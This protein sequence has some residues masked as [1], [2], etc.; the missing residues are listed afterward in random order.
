MMYLIALMRTLKSMIL[1]CLSP[2]LE[3][4]CRSTVSEPYNFVHRLHVEEDLTWKDLS[5]NEALSNLQLVEK[6]G[7]GYVWPPLYS[8]ASKIALSHPL[9]PLDDDPLSSDLMVRCTKREQ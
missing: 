9:S 4:G 8:S 1:S 3:H 2:E 7:E 6:L 5:G